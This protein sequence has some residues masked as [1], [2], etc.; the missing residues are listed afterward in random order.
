MLEHF[1]PDNRED[2]DN[3]LT[4]NLGRKFKSHQTQLMT[5]LLQRKK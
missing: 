3:E 1:V 5:K 4:E 2:S